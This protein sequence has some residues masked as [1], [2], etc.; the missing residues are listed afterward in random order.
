M[1]TTST[2]I[3][4]GVHHTN[5][6]WITN[7]SC[8]QQLLSKNLREE[9]CTSTSITTPKKNEKKQIRYVVTAYKPNLKHYTSTMQVCSKEKLKPSIGE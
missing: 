4:W 8:S 7:P 5:T 1:S 6:S 3:K 2:T 9:P